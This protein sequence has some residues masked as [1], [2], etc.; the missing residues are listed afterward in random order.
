[1][2]AVMGWQLSEPSVVPR[3]SFQRR[4]PVSLSTAYR[5]LS[6]PPINTKSPTTTGCATSTPGVSNFHLR[7]RL[8]AL[9]GESLTSPG[10][11][12]ERATSWRNM[13]QSSSG[14]AAW[15]EGVTSVRR[16]TA[17]TTRRAAV[18]YRTLRW[19]INDSWFQLLSPAAGS[20]IIPE[21]RN[22]RLGGVKRKT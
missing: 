14:A 22:S 9:A 15:V 19:D 3:S 20:E 13:G 7:C 11:K 18:Q 2:P 1:M 17:T 10:L 4:S 5:M 8:G 16:A 6:H 12:E 21:M